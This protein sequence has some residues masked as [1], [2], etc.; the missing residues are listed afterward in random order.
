MLTFPEVKKA[1]AIFSD[2]VLLERCIKSILVLDAWSDGA[3][4]ALGIKDDCEAH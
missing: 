2:L 4:K 3:I 1:G